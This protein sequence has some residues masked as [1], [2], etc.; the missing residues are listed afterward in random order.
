MLVKRL[1]IFF[2]AR[3][4][5]RAQSMHRSHQLVDMVTKGLTL[6]CHTSSSSV[7]YSNVHTLNLTHAHAVAIRPSF[8]SPHL[9]FCA[10]HC[11]RVRKRP[12][13]EARVK[14]ISELHRGHCKSQVSEPSIKGAKLNDNGVSAL[15]LLIVGQN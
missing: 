11:T 9:I 3:D 6:N 5:F 4:T 13:D 15:Y 14:A 1:V 8:S 10:Y 7:T 2:F 12:G